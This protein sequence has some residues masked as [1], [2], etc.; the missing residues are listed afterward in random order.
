MW[1]VV[2][3]LGLEVALLNFVVRLFVVSIVV[4]VLSHWFGVLWSNVLIVMSVEVHLRVSV[5]RF[6]VMLDVPSL[7][8][9]GD[10]LDMAAMIRVKVCSMGIAMLTSGA[11]LSSEAVLVASVLRIAVRSGVA[12]AFT[13]LA[14]VMSYAT[15]VAIV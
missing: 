12:V 3:I 10:Y 11:V 7:M 5:M 2:V 4:D 13:V 14:L 9:L 15:I 6:K 8:Q 1:L